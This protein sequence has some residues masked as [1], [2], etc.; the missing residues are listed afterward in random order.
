MVC[1]LPARADSG[2]SVALLAAT[3]R[4]RG[5]LLQWRR[6]HLVETYVCLFF[7]IGQRQKERVLEARPRH[8]A[9]GRHHVDALQQRPK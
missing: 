9:H 2:A 6:R 5:V 4:R 7:L 3:G 1:I 8:L